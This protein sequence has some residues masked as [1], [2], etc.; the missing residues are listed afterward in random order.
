MIRLVIGVALAMFFASVAIGQVAGIISASR[1]GR[2][3]SFVPLIGG[4][5]G[6]IAVWL[7]PLPGWSMIVPL[8]LDLGCLPWLVGAVAMLCREMIRRGEA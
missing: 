5:A 7:L 3:Y 8:V 1:R 4:V 6:A 2:G